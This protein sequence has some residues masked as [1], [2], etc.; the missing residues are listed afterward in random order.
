MHPYQKTK[1]LRE[2]IL[3]FEE[4]RQQLDD[5]LV[6]VQSHLTTDIVAIDEPFGPSITDGNLQVMVL[7]D[8]ATGF[9]NFEYP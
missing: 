4:R 5:F 9:S 2:L 6:S 3:P 7:S 1:L 8:E